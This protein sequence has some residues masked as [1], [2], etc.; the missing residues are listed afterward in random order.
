MSQE[1]PNC[2]PAGKTQDLETYMKE[3]DHVTAD[4]RRFAHKMKK[5]KSH[6]LGPV[7]HPSIGRS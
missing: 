4:M 7:P 2:S 6:L 1:K 5:I 3:V